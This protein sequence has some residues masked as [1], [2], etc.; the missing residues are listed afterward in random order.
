M[1]AYR[2]IQPNLKAC[3]WRL[4]VLFVTVVGS[5]SVAVH[6]ERVRTE[7]GVEKKHTHA[8]AVYGGGSHKSAVKVRCLLSSAS[9]AQK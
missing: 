5:A 2:N 6:L 4:T 7:A 8:Y 9:R 1:W 3:T